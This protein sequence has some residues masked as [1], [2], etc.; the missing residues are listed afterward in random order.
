MG[1]KAQ[2]W[3]GRS[4]CSHLELPINSYQTQGYRTGGTDRDTFIFCIRK[5]H[6]WSVETH[7]RWQRI[8][9]MYLL[10]LECEY[11]VSALLVWHSH[12]FLPSQIPQEKLKVHTARY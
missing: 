1:T 7:S 12:L 2:V 4:F 11:T 9:G 6:L 8:V 5:T 10:I 3:A